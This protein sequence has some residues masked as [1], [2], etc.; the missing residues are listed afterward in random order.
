[1]PSNGD[2]DRRALALPRDGFGF[3]LGDLNLV[4]GKMHLVFDFGG[5]TDE[6]DAVVQ[7]LADV[8][9]SEFDAR[10][11]LNA[12]VFQLGLERDDLL[13]GLIELGFGRISLIGQAFQAAELLLGKR[14]LL[15]QPVELDL[16]L[17]DVLHFDGCEPA[18]FFKL[19][20]MAALE[21]RQLRLALLHGDVGQLDFAFELIV[22][23]IDNDIAGL[24][25][26]RRA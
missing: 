12:P 4:L 8:L 26:R 13:A 16:A 15:L 3:L 18:Q 23:D 25:L 19:I 9:I 21:E 10:R 11:Q 20:Q 5:L 6:V 22:D 14:Q 17:L 2:D 24:D 7:P 1:M